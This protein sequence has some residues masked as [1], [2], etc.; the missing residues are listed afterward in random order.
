MVKSPVQKPKYQTWQRVI[1]SK[2][3][4]VCTSDSRLIKGFALGA[5]AS[6]DTEYKAA[7]GTAGNWA[8]SYA[9]KLEMLS[10]HRTL[11]YCRVV[12]ASMIEKHT[13]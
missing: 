11:G 4:Y 8:T 1:D 13:V 9:V 5:F 2:P 6:G 7:N 12:S 10:R 3:A